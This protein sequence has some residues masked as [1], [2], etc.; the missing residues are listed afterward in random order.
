MLVCKSLAARKKQRTWEGCPGPG[1]CCNVL[2]TYLPVVTDKRRTQYTPNI[3]AQYN[4]IMA[5][6]KAISIPLTVH[7]M[8]GPHETSILSLRQNHASSH[9]NTKIRWQK[10][11]DAH[12]LPVAGTTPAI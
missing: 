1:S 11:T 3:C 2:L 6:T 5:T 10:K 8:T 9:K 4:I 7:R 12:L